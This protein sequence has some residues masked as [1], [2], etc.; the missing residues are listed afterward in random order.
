M[1]RNSGADFGRDKKT[2]SLQDQG[3]LQ[4]LSGVK[5]ISVYFVVKV[6][7]DRSQKDWNVVVGFIF[8]WRQV[9][10]L[11]V[12][13]WLQCMV[14]LPFIDTTRLETDT[15]HNH[16]V[17]ATSAN[18]ML[19]SARPLNLIPDFDTAIGNAAAAIID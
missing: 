11:H 1:L 5:S 3:E 8:A 14:K 7:S 12:T 9:P 16:L 19:L 15:A 4:V 18:L 10:H 17:T 13:L 2:C 6:V